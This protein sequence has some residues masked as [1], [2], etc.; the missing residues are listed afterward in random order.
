MGLRALAVLTKR[1]Y[2]QIVERF[3]ELARDT[4][5]K[6]RTIPDI[7]A[8]LDVGRRTLARAVRATR[9]TTPARHLRDL[10]LA[11]AHAALQ[12]SAAS[13]GAASS[14]RPRLNSRQRCG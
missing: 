6:P 12:D 5:G 14:M 10:A 9:G 11:A 4:L 13:S 3:E 7:C 1:R 8:T 2:R